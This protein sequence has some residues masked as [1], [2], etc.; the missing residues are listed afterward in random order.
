[1]ILALNCGSSSVKFQVFDSKTKQSL[2]KGLLERIGQAD[3]VV[4]YSTKDKGP[5]PINGKSFRDHHEAIA[6]MKDILFDPEIGVI[7]QEADLL[8][9]GH[10][11]VHGGDRFSGSQ[12]INEEV[13]ATIRALQEIAPLHNPPN[14]EGILGAQKFFPHLP[15]VAVFDTAFHQTMPDHVFMYAVPYEWYAKYGVRR[16]GFHGT[17]HYYVSRRAI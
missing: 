5:V 1:M 11:V 2:A 16:Y 3:P 13:L 10:R 15:H 17:S 8:A 4:T 7:E 12:I 14:L 9:V 6:V